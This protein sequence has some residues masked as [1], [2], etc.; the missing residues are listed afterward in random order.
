MEN[1]ELV[2][3]SEGHNV[4]DADAER[5]DVLKFGLLRWYPLDSCLFDDRK[6][7]IIR[8]D[9]DGHVPGFKDFLEIMNP[10]NQK[11]ESGYLSLISTNKV[12]NQ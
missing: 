2:L 4:E 9:D 5:T 3:F 1:V 10:G 7:M 6:G 12:L 11:A 8:S